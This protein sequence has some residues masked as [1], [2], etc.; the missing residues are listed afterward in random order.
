MPLASDEIRSF[1]RL[2][3]D[4]DISREGSIPSFEKSQSVVLIVREKRKI[5]QNV[6]SF[7]NLT[8]F[9][10]LIEYSTFLRFDGAENFHSQLA[11]KHYATITPRNIRNILVTKL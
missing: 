1:S 8:K 4:C 5:S 9:E 3:T 7:C 10:R 11:Q 2:S 6:Y